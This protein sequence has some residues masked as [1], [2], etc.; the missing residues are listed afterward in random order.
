MARH[1][2]IVIPGLPHLV[3]QAG[4][5][6]QPVVVD[7]HDAQ[8]WLAIV[9]EVAATQRVLLHG[10][11]LA[12]DRY[13]LMVTPPS[14]ASL[15]RLVQDLG[16]R[17]VGSFN[18]RHGRSGTLWE[19]R[20]RST[21]LQPGLW[22]R[23]ALLWLENPVP[24]WP[25]LCT[26]EHH[27]GHAEL[28]GVVDPKAYWSLGNTPFE[29]QAA[30]LQLLDGG[31]AGADEDALLRSL[32]SSRPLGDAAWQDSLQGLT[33]VPLQRRPRG[34]PRKTTRAAEPVNR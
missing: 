25:G 22:E 1:A 28:H 13:L 4:H 24:A 32:R 26:R 15:S 3:M 23:R 6:G 17:Y 10:W 14:A 11:R 2:R 21:V 30:W 8:R 19:G 18:A 33:P 12:P 5:N 9:R 31:L 7:P 16:R 34:R 27:L 29:R 20:F